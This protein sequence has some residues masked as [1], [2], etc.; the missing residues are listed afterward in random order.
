MAP[1]VQD[2][3]TYVKTI[4]AS[5]P[6]GSPYSLAIP[7]SAREDRS[8]IYRHYQFVD[9]PLLQTIDPECL[10]SHDFFEK[11][12]RKRPNARCLGHRPWDPVTKTYGN[13]QW[14]TYAKTAERRKNFGVGLV[15]LH[16]RAGI[17]DDKY[18]V[19]LWCQ[20][21]PEWQIVDLG[22]M[23][24]SL[25]T[26]SIYDT[27]G[28]D[29]TEYIVN[30]ATLACVC[31]TLPHIP[32]L[33]K[34]APRVPTLKLIICLD[35]LDE[36]EQPGN[37]KKALLN[38]LAAEVGIAI[39]Y[40]GDVEAIGAASPNS[41][42]NPPR[43]EDIIT[44]NYTSGTTGN[45]KGVVLTQ[46]HAVAAT[47]I[48]RI[49][50]DPWPNDVLCSYLP[51]A[52]IYQRLAEHGC[53]AVGSAIGY[54]RGDILGL[55]DDLKLLR[56]TAFNSVPRLYN[57]FGGAIK[58]ATIDAPGM[59]GTI[60]RHIINTKL[61]SM[62]LPPGQATNKHALYDRIWT[63][64][65]A[66]A[67]GLQRAR[68][69]VTGSAPIDPGLHQF[70]RA[71]F[72]AKFIQGYGLTETY[73]HGLVQYDDDYSTGNCGGVSPSMEVCLESVPDMEYLATDTPNPRGEILL[74]GTARFREYYRNEA[75]TS[76][77]IDADGWFH[78]GDIGEVDSMGRFKIIDRRK[79]VLKLAQGEYISPER[80]ENV[81]LAN[82]NLL[83]QAYVH[84]DSTQAFLVAIFGVD[85][86]TFAPW[87]SKILGREI[88]SDDIAGLKEAGNDKR[89]RMQLVKVLEGVGKK[90]K[91][92]S[93]E[94]VKNVYLDIEPFTID[95]ELLTPTLKLKR[96]QTAKKFRE[97]IDTMYAEALAEEKPVAK[98]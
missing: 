67:F 27:L 71:A 33:L 82:C 88:K 45:P 60:G 38:A 72:G 21:R 43:P 29:T 52:H 61:A 70:L 10:T 35:R 91:F 98:L 64:K 76:K 94:K 34:L 53:L 40:I 62:K 18:G 37:T 78:T 20:N 84:G 30:H 16:K 59:K 25:F 95:N 83:A 66:S 11:A 15:E 41:P 96:P 17:T 39:H 51:L 56:P 65:L 23:S 54:F 36:G 44:I 13:Y 85:P 19:G 14:I 4:R 89:V 92:N 86:V 73:A 46:A 75:E 48:S 12:A 31:T 87:A 93:Y 55:V 28:P 5:P 68:G 9:K 63:P 2:P 1:T 42:M 22:A 69:M 81:Y 80:I 57:R 3:D 8:G 7:G 47:S 6:P 97:H 58:A 50:S 79:N 24:Q 74:R 77:A 32:T 26:V 49:V 90:S